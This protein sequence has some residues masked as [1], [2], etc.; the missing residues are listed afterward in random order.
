MSAFIPIPKKGNAKNVLITAQQHSFHMLA[1]SWAKSSK[2]GFNSMW[3]KSFQMFKLDFKKAE[4]PEIKLLTSIGSQKKQENSRKKKIYFCFIDYTKVFDCG[5]YKKTVKILKEIE[6]T[7][8]SYQP[9]EKPVCRSVRNSQN[10]TWNN[11][12]VPYWERSMSRLYIVTLL[13]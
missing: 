8:L 5:A 1:R 10:W 3:T 4:K 11:R 7:R 13:I 6:N 12:L 9:P 2:L